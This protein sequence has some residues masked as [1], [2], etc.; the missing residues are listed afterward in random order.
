MAMRPLEKLP[1]IRSKLGSVIVVAVAI[2]LL[3]SYLVIGFALRNSPRD[4]E[5]IK[6]LR[7]ANTAA[8]GQIA[9]IPAGH[10]GRGAR[11]IGSAP[12]RPTGPS[13]RSMPP[14]FMTGFHI[15]ASSVRS[16]TRAS[17]PPTA[18]RSR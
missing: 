10:G 2:T 4:S 1:T 15:G 6:T 13:I 17:R 8:A 5:A 9:E 14:V 11:P 18:A 7:K 3:I 12:P 16:R